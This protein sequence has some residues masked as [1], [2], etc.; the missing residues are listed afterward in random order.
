[1]K[2]LIPEFLVLDTF[3]KTSTT[4]LLSFYLARSS[5]SFTHVL[6]ISKSLLL[7]IKLIFFPLLCWL[8]I[9]HL[10]LEGL[11][12]VLTSLVVY[13]LILDYCW[14]FWLAFDAGQSIFIICILVILQ[15]STFYSHYVF[16]NSFW[17]FDPYLLASFRSNFI[18]FGVHV[19]FVSNW[20]KVKSKLSPNKLDMNE[21]YREEIIILQKK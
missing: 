18:C 7:L 13:Y 8:V 1:M 17:D 15:V 9:I 20:W 11:S 16:P 2:A 4:I 3:F 10:I 21:S 12:N 5:V 19:N 14:W 6:N